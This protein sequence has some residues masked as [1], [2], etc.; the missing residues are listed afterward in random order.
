[1]HRIR[2]VIQHYAWGDTDV[3]PNLLGCEPDG[4][5]WAEYWLGTHPR[6]MATLD[7]GRSLSDLTGELPYLLKV[8]A[9]AQPLSLQTHPNAARAEAGFAAGVFGDPSPK[10]ELLCAITPVEALCGIRPAP[11]TAALFAELG[12]DNLAERVR[13]HGPG[14]LLHDIYRGH[15]DPSPIIAACGTS[16]RREAHWVRVLDEMYPGDPSVAATLLLNLIRLEPGEAIRL[17]AGNLHAYLHGAGIELMAASD[18]V[19]RGGLTTKPVDIDLLLDTV[20]VTSLADPVL[21]KAQRFDLPAAGVALVVLETGQSHRSAG[22]EIMITAAGESFLL[23]SD[24][25]YEATTTSWVV[26]AN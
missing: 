8:L 19:V 1:M 5:P 23:E 10:P 25:L 12:L 3:I 16:D 22:N 24:D 11:D 14:S 20:D 15:V 21:A 26:V 17:E 7:D 4:Q 18:N 9:A 13:I 6:G 2:G